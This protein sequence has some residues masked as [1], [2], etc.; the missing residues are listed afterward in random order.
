MKKIFW[1]TTINKIDMT[2]KANILERLITKTKNDT[3]NPSNS[4]VFIYNCHDI[5]PGIMEEMNAKHQLN[6]LILS[7]SSE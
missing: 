7:P 3:Q 4:L 5:H 2:T 1:Q 6:S